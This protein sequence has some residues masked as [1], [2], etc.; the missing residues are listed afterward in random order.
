M[1]ASSFFSLELQRSV[2]NQN[3]LLRDVLDKLE[4]SGIPQA[5]ECKELI[6]PSPQSLQEKE[7]SD[8]E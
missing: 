4:N 2:D 8:L 7:I 1:D 3:T 5:S 6:K